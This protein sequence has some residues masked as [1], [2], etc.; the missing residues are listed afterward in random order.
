MALRGSGIHFKVK[1]Y[2]KKFCEVNHINNDKNLRKLLNS[3]AI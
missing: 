1:N 2:E 3:V